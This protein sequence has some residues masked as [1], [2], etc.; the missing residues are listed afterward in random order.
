[1]KYILGIESTAHTFGI[2][3]INSKGETLS[4]VT[5]TKTSTEGGF[6]PREAAEHHYLLAKELLEKAL[7]QANLSIN[8]I[9]LIGFSQSPFLSERA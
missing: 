1:M 8:D 9:D 3:I 6:L 2:G 4:N 7:T 5:D